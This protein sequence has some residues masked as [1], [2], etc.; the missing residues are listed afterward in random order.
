MSEIEYNGIKM[1]EFVFDEMKRFKP[2]QKVKIKNNPM[3]MAYL[4]NKCEIIK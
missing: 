4:A 1:Y 3:T 2:E